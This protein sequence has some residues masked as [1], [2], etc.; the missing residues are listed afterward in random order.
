[1]Y[2]LRP[3]TFLNQKI[4]YESIFTRFKKY[5]RPAHPP[6]T[7]FMKDIQSRAATNLSEHAPF[8]FPAND[9]K[10]NDRVPINALEEKL[11]IIGNE[12]ERSE[13]EKLQMKEIDRYL[14][15]NTY[16]HEVAANEERIN[17]EFVMQ[18][19]FLTKANDGQEF[20]NLMANQDPQEEIINPKIRNFA[21]FVKEAQSMSKT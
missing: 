8:Q 11:M 19:K 5:L 18:R 17:S 9:L 20:L 6:T 4:R 15:T 1:M 16:F 7:N 10:P 3:K 14:G 12:K 13:I 21:Q 2:R